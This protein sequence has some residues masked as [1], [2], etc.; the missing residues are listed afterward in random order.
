MLPTDQ[1][2]MTL[3]NLTPQFKTVL[4]QH[5]SVEKFVRVAQTAILTNQSIANCERNSIYAACIKSAEHG[6]LPDG[7]EGSIVPFG[8]KAVFMPMIG[9]I[10]K[11]IRNSGELSSITAQAIYENDF[12]DYGVNKEGEYIEF[13]PL[14]FGERGAMIGV[15]A[16][17]ITKD[18]ASYVEVM[19]NE[20]INKVR[21]SSRS[22]NSGPWKDWFEEMSK[23]TVIR[24]LAKRLPMST[25]LESVVK[26]VD[27][28]YDF[29]QVEEEKEY[30][31]STSRLSRL[32]DNKL[33]ENDNDVKTVSP[34]KEGEVI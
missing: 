20:Q 22:K 14:L 27:Q 32:V 16:M 8:N 19:T 2:K 17:A 29:K 24:R 23:K 7:N 9:G 18:N 33:E 25:D 26:D 15:F 13:K 4:P 1:I 3:T 30:T 21:E 6:L 10:L 28:Y 31:A 12:F 34:S 5:I 11:K